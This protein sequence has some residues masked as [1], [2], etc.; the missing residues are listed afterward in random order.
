[1]WEI[2]LNLRLRHFGIEIDCRLT[3]TIIYVIV[4][5]CMN[6]QST[7]LSSST[8]K[9]DI[10]CYDVSLHKLELGHDLRIQ[11][12]SITTS[13]QVAVLPWQLMKDGS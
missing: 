13:I 3:W 6:I 5:T 2:M 4:Y 8:V 7:V 9:Q 10:G 1:M 11:V 12:P